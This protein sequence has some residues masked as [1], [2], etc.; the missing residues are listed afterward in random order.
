MR[1]AACTPARLPEDQGGTNWALCG[2]PG[3]LDV[4]A[5][6]AGDRLPNGYSLKSTFDGNSPLDDRRPRDRATRATAQD[7]GS[8]VSLLT[9]T[10]KLDQHRVRRPD[11]QP[12]RR[13][14]DDHRHRR[15]DGH[16]AASRQAL[17]LPDYTPA[18]GHHRCALGSPTFEP[19]RHGQRLRHH[20]QRRR[21]EGVVTSSRGSR[22]PTAR[23][24]YKHEVAR[25]TRR[26]RR[27]SP[28]TSPTRCSRSSKAGSGTAALGLG[29]PAAGKTGTSTTN[30][31]DVVRPRGSS[32][33]PRSSSTAVMYVRG[34]GND[35]LN[36]YMPTFFGGEYPA[37]TWTDDH[38]PRAGGRADRGVPA[39]G[40]RRR[41]R[42]PSTSTAVH[43][44][45]RRRRHQGNDETTPTETDAEPPTPTR[46]DRRR[47]EPTDAR[48]SRRRRAT[49]CFLDPSDCVTE[50]AVGAHRRRWRHLRPRDRGRL[51]ETVRRQ[52]RVSTVRYALRRMRRARPP[53]P[54]RPVVAEAS[55]SI[56][57]PVGR[58]ARPHPWWTPVRVIL[59]VA[60]VTF[61]LGHAAEDAVRLRRS[62]TDQSSAT[63]RMCYSDVPYLYAGAASPSEWPFT[64][65]DVRPLPGPRVPRR[66]RLLRLRRRR[67][68][69]PARRLARPRRARSQPDGELSGTDEVRREVESSSLGHRRRLRRDRAAGGVLLRRSPAA[70]L[71][72]RDLR[73]LA[74]AGADRPD[75]LGLPR[76]RRSSP[77]RCWP[78]RADDRC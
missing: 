38:E 36:G 49:S 65:N 73:A 1:S 44:D 70:A 21:R 57:G 33:S 7:Y 28:T 52:A 25:P 45:R 6:R 35:P 55:E 17:R 47:R 53:H 10:Q 64:D 23:T 72:R 69:P 34:D 16:P 63:A 43:A 56:G 15:R 11:R 3:R 62:R 12:G 14:G 51:R 2:R 71:G 31:G 24:L 13:A 58:R 9:A 20:R 59:A 22:T 54:G 27:T 77:A 41:R 78:G 18:R 48:R 42:P 68:H 8:R 66:H 32:G 60:C 26:S 30:D 5:V 50:S 39:A 40:Q 29:R 61:L 46:A 75:Q 67:G 19:D 74:G 76:G 4:Q 37:A